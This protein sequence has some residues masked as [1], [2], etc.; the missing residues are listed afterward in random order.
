MSSID[1]RLRTRWRIPPVFHPL[2]RPKR[3][4]VFWG[5][6]GGAKTVTV[7]TIIVGLLY[8][9]PPI[10]GQPFRVL[11]GREYQNSIDESVH[12]EIVAAIQRLGLVPYFKISKAGVVCLTT[13]AQVVYRGMHNNI[14]Q[15]K[16]LGGIDLFWGEEA[17]SFTED[18]L[19]YIDP[20]I[21]RDPPF[22]PF[23]MGSELWFTFNQTLDTDPIYRM[24]KCNL[25][26]WED[27]RHLV[28]PCTWKDNY[29]EFTGANALVRAQEAYPNRDAFPPHR[30]IETDGVVK[31]ITFPQVL[32]DQRRDMEAHDDQG[33]YQWVWGTSCRNLGGIFFALEHLLV[34]GQ[35][36]EYPKTCDSVFAVIDTASKTGRENDGTAVTYFATN[37]HGAGIPLMV[38]DYDI[39]QI[40]GSFLEVWLPSVFM[41]LKDLAAQCGA[42]YGS[43]GAFIED[44]NSGT[45]LIQQAQNRNLPAQGIDSKLTAMGKVERC[46]SVS[47]YVNRG[48]VKFSRLAFEK[49]VPY[50]G[51]T[52]NHLLTQ[53]RSFRVSDVETME[54]DGLDTFAYGIAIALGNTEGF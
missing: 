46:I 44:K 24:Y 27:A 31:V 7:A 54:N 8:M 43:V 3:Y 42:R 29:V 25:G 10:Q 1:D 53:V 28:V 9:R 14:D 37:R 18:S 11:C 17:H 5:G 52:A 41:R 30:F 4:K 45:V 51:I 22:G 20:T 36:P 49:V 38:L 23:G 47:G 15:I 2:I 32:E 16:S 34:H 39:Q 33:F 26:R 50:K 6:R 48:M 40:Q 19:I 13:G 12:F 21:R 35:P